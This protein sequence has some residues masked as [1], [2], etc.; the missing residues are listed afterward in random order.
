MFPPKYPS[1]KQLAPTGRRG[2][3]PH[4]LE[5]F[6]SEGRRDQFKSTTPA[7]DY[8]NWKPADKTVGGTLNKWSALPR[9]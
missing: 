3:V 6:D 5:T 8:R 7:I 4:S 9:N 2:G 1:Y